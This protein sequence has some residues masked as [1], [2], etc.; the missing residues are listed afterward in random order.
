MDRVPEAIAVA[1]CSSCGTGNGPGA[2]FC[3][4]CATPLVAPCP[5]CATTNPPG[6]RFCAACATPLVPGAL[7]AAPLPAPEP[8]AERR[9]VA[10][11][12]ADLVGFTPYA[13]ERDA[14]EVRE[15]LTR[16]FDLARET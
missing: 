1:T 11:L 6:A 12:F 2:R 8:V 15:T 3:T 14:E 4:E 10:V 13:A 16:Y 9:L 5:A 7:R